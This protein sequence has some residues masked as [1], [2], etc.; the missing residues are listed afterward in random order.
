MFV[1][2]EVVV[3]VVLA[4]LELVV[5]EAVVFAESASVVFRVLVE[6]ELVDVVSFNFVFEMAWQPR[7]TAIINKFTYVVFCFFASE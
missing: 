6:V 1:M 3:L 4:E 7:L 2:L 5:S